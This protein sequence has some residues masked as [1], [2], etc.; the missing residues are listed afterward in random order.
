MTWKQVTRVHLRCDATYER[1]QGQRSWAHIC[2]H[3]R[4]PELTCACTCVLM[5]NFEE[6]YFDRGVNL[7]GLSSNLTWL[8]NPLTTSLKEI[9]KKL[10]RSRV[11]GRTDGQT[12]FIFQD[13]KKRRS[14]LI[15]S[16][17]TAKNVPNVCSRD[18]YGSIIAIN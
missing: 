16:I 2:A 14:R 3:V 5:S 13:L 4:A 7:L 10:N 17:K 11:I 1:C 15:F 6:S 9:L 12:V 18:T 8:L